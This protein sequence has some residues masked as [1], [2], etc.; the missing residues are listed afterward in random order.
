MARLKLPRP[1]M[2]VVSFRVEE[3]E[4]DRWLRAARKAKARSF[5]AWLRKT[6]NEALQEADSG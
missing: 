3:A 1:R 5:S 2:V 6:L 4:R